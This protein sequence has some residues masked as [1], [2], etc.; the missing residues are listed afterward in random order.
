MGFGTHGRAPKVMLVLCL[1]YAAA[2]LIHFAHNAE[3]LADYPNMPRWLS[4]AKVYVAWLGLTAIGAAGFLL[5][6][7]GFQL[8]GL[9]VIALYAVLGFDS[10][11]HYVV[12][13]FSAHTTM[14]HFTIWLDVVAAAALL[15][16]VAWLLLQ[17]MR[18]IHP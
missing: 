10:L 3:F 4:R 2:S 18:A 17:R 11:T 14:M 16:T 9:L 13:P 8:T 1:L 5:L 7:R 15:M 6:Y 12:A